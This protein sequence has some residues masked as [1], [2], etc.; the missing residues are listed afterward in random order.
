MA[1]IKL[2]S[3][4]QVIE[5][6]QTD[7]GVR[8]NSLSLKDSDFKV[9]KG[10]ANPIEF[11]IRD[12]NRRPVS[13]A[14]R[15]VTITVLNFFTG[16]AVFQKEADIIDEAKGKI[17]VT[18]L[19]TE[20][21]HW[22]PC[23]FKYSFNVDF[24]DGA[25]IQMLFIDQNHNA[26]GFFEFID[27]C[28]PQPTVSFRVLREE[29]TA[30]NIAPPT[31]TPTV[32]ISSAFPGDASFGEDDGLHTVAVYANNFAGKFYVQGSL[33]EVP[34]VEEKDWFD[35]F[36]TSFTPFFEFGN[37]PGPDDTFTGIEAFNFTGS[38]RW[39][40]FKFTEDADN[41]GQITQVLYRN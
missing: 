24:C 1:A 2:Y 35:I 4:P 30:T 10:S 14:G 28:L 9:Y 13:L 20:T 38:V 31:T 33:E 15:T 12:N 18:F 37:T 41:P 17:L 16:E 36:L 7:R 21:A 8:N 11:I 6:I 34:E 40:R 5:L 39:V 23:F 25:T 29:F 26:C 3:F 22:E 32:F 19:I 27:G